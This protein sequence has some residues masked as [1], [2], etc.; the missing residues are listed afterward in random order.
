MFFRIALLL[1]FF[2]LVA[3]PAKACDLTE[4]Q[5]GID[6]CKQQ[7]DV[8]HSNTQCSGSGYMSTHARNGD[9][10]GVRDGFANC[11]FGTDDG[12]MKQ[13]FNVEACFLNDPKGLLR[14][15]AQYTADA[16]AR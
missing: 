7:C 12:E 10:N 3:S 16:R 4:A 15:P 14:W 11:H 8:N 5:V 9:A 2:A 13:K 6:W 1:A